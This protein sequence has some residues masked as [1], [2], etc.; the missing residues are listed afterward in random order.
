MKLIVTVTS[1]Y[2]SEAETEIEVPDGATAEMINTIVTTRLLRKTMN[3]PS[4]HDATWKMS[5]LAVSQVDANGDEVKD[6][7]ECERNW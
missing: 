6:W 4:K 5:F 3:L 1:E 2:V 7:E